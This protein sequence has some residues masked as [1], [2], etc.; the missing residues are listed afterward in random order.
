MS[1]E[2]LFLDTAFVIGLLNWKDQYHGKAKEL[3]PRFRAA[4]EVWTTEAILV[5]IGNHLS[6][7]QHR[8]TAIRF[9]QQC[10]AN[11]R[12][13]IVPATTNLLNRALDLYDS[14]KDKTWGLTDCISFVVMQDETLADAIT[15][16]RHFQQAGFRALMQD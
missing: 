6:S 5:E 7:I 16:D 3:F 8:R 13:R 10:H 12:M 4:G 2:R 11:S 1:N 15:T 9:I 14:H